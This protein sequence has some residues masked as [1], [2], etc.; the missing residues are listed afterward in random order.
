[1]QLKFNTFSYSVKSSSYFDNRIGSSLISLNDLNWPTNLYVS[2]TVNYNNNYRYVGYSFL[3][4]INLGNRTLRNKT[5]NLDLI[6]AEDVKDVY[7]ENNIQPISANIN[8]IKKGIFKSQQMVTV[9]FG[10][11]HIVDS[12]VCVKYNDGIISKYRISGGYNNKPIVT[13]GINNKTSVVGKTI[14]IPMNFYDF[15]ND[16]IEYNLL[17]NGT[18]VSSGSAISN[19]TIYNSFTPITSGLNTFNIS[20][21]DS[22]GEIVISQNLYI[23]VIY[24]NVPSGFFI[25]QSHTTFPYRKEYVEFNLKDLDFDTISFDL[26]CNGDLAVSG[27]T[28]RELNIKYPISLPKGIYNYTLILKDIFVDSDV[29]QGP[30]IKVVDQILVNNY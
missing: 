17:N 7:V 22:I 15:D 11:S 21:C 28:T 24:D 9:D 29:I 10:N 4:S 1:M 6:N 14:Q 27:T 18:I 20:A 23:D 5:I 3:N 16:I 2:D 30:I 19:T 8:L 25:T 26:Y 12:F 13:F